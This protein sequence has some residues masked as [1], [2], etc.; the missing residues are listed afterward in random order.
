M[1]TIILGTL[2]DGPHLGYIAVSLTITALLLW[3]PFRFIKSQKYKD[4]YLK[5]W[6][7]ATLFLHLSPLWIAFLNGN[8]AIAAD[9]MLFPIY[10]C[11]LSMYLLVIVA[12]WGNKKTK[13]FNY[14]ATV[15]AYA[16]MF[17][18]LISLFY[19]D[20]YL[21]G[22]TIFEWG[23]F[24]SMLSHSTMLI[25]CLYL[26]VGGYFKVNRYNVVTYTIGL[27]F[28]G[29]V[30]LIVNWTFAAAGLNAPNAMYLQHPPIEDV[31]FLNVYVI[32]ALM[33]LLVFG[34]SYTI[35][36]ISKKMAVLKRPLT[37]TE[38]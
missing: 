18:A 30:G 33:V 7:L 15:V 36:V 31:P 22:T 27:L 12:L 35:E 4:I 37:Q 11:N 16:G 26:F 24:K 29:A 5:V 32:A 13:F 10:F 25:G 17:G 23:V 1:N 21:H 3:L 2:F 19:P 9:N 6:A 38:N 28:F 34:I 14:M 8:P 20:Y